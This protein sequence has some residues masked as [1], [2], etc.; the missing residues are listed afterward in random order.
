MSV[1]ATLDELVAVCRTLDEARSAA[2]HREDLIRRLAAQG[3]AVRRIPALVRERLLLEGFTPAQISGLGVSYGA[4][5]Q[6]VERSGGTRS[7]P[8]GEGRA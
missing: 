4:V 2:G 3:V 6:T 5:R 1:E 8:R 7:T